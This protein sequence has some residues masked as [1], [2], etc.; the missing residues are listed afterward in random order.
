MRS[1][2]VASFLISATILLPVFVVLKALP[3]AGAGAGPT[4]APPTLQA[5]SNSN[6]FVVNATTNCSDSSSSITSTQIQWGPG[7]TTNGTTGSFT[8]GGPEDSGIIGVIATD[9][10][11]SSTTV[12]ESLNLTTPSFVEQGRSVQFQIGVLPIPGLNV[13]VTFSCVSTDGPNGTQSLATYHLSCA[14]SN[15]QSSYPLTLNGSAPSPSLQLTIQTNSASS[16]MM[17]H[18]TIQGMPV[19]LTYAG[20][21]PISALIFVR[22]SKSVGSRQMS[23]ARY[24]ALL[25]MLTV[26]A[27]SLACGGSSSSSSSQATP[28]GSYTITMRG[29]DGS[30]NSQ[31]TVLVGFQVSQ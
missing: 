3:A 2:G 6:P 19:W 24:I 14:F 20:V 4:C 27:A 13:N 22:W 21:L 10:A 17:A 30:G 7:E 11:G 28:P 9:T 12:L 29:M 5:G 31:A 15:G 18:P 16:A 23:L 26:V 8:Y 25:A 1:G